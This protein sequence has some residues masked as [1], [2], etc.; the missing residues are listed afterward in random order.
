[1][2]ILVAHFKGKHPKQI[3]VADARYFLT[4]RRRKVNALALYKEICV[5]KA[6]FNWLALH[7]VLDKSHN[8]FREAG[9]PYVRKSE[10]VSL[11]KKK[12]AELRELLAKALF[13]LPE[14]ERRALRLLEKL[15]HPEPSPA[16]ST[17][18]H[19][20]EGPEFERT[21]PLSSP[22]PSL[23]QESRPAR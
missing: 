23:S 7:S 15:P 14:D 1:M 9:R 4:Q 13:P 22:S 10:Q 12:V 19:K 16:P 6:F 5:Y 17:P 20:T 2:D 3:F 11:S 21:T 18:P 8:P